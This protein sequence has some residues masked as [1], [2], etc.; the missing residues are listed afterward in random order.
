MIF[1][2][3]K[4]YLETRRPKSQ[5]SLNDGYFALLLQQS[6]QLPLQNLWDAEFRVYSQWGEDG[7]LNFLCENLT[8]IRPKMIEF[9]SG[10][11]TEC[12][13]RFLA[14]FR[15]A[16]VAPID[17][18][19]DLIST[20]ENLDVNW[21]STICPIETWITPTNVNVLFEKANKSLVGVDIV[22]LDIDGNDYWVA[23]ALDF[24]ETKIIVVEYNP[25]FG[26]ELALTVPRDDSFNRTESHFSNL[27]YGASLVA[28]INL[29]KL[30]NYTFVGSNRAGNNAFFVLNSALSLLKVRIP[31]VKE[32]GNFTDW[33][34]RESRST[35]GILTFLSL[36]EGRELIK[37]LDLVQL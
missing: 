30:K 32:Y 5:K 19:N 28:F 37:D 9:G 4:Q 3:A 33:R 12:N 18:R 27:Y 8:I 1:K 15:N 14:E 34:V 25:I 26:H 11:F 29:F 31:T 36:E 23:E 20:I 13:S 35:N 24:K 16:S 2:R 6:L 17:S 22:S 10:N 21:R 7:I